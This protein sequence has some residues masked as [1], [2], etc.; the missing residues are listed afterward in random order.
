MR[1]GRFRWCSVSLPFLPF[2]SARH[3]HQFEIGAYASFT[4]YDHAFSL[5]N[6]I[7]G[8]GRS[9]TSS[10]Q[11]SASSSTWATSS[12]RPQA[13]APL[14][15]SPRGGSLVLK[16]RQRAQPLLY[17]GG[18]SR[19]QV[20]GQSH[21]QLQPITAFT[22]RSANRIF[23]RRVAV[24]IGRRCDL[25]PEDGFSS[26]TGPDTCGSPGWRFSPGK[27]YKG[28]GSRRRPADRRSVPGTQPAGR[29]SR[30]VA[31]RLRSDKSTMSRRLPNTVEE[32]KSMLAAVP[33]MPTRWR[34]RTGIDSSGTATGARVDATGCPTDADSDGV[35]DGPDQCPNTR[36]RQSRATGAGGQRP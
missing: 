4:R 9:V 34:V 32:L 27:L 19:P 23:R 31:E 25:F 33:R 20:R 17:P 13:G 6:Q 24:R 30:R 21:L 2:A 36:R 5:D 16:P 22:A 12:P 28:H 15:R 7:G 35:P 1:A 8:G 11:P 29:G 18:Y 26:G 10:V 3:T 14:P